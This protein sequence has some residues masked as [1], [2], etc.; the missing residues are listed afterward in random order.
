MKFMFGYILFFPKNCVL[1]SYHSNCLWDAYSSKLLS[2]VVKQGMVVG[3]LPVLIF[4]CQLLLFVRILEPSK[5]GRL[6][7]FDIL[8]RKCWRPRAVTIHINKEMVSHWNILVWFNFTLLAKPFLL[9][10]FTPSTP[11]FC[12]FFVKEETLTRLSLNYSI[13]DLFRFLSYHDQILRS[14]WYFDGKYIIDLQHW[15]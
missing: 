12:L 6:F 4:L 11:I 7:I 8:R 5:F 9:S 2:R 14:H 1:H 10:C 13:T 3:S 15:L